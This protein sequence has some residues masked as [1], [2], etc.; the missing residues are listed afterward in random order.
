MKL[1][2]TLLIIPKCYF[3]WLPTKQLHIAT[4]KLAMA[5]KFSI[6]AIEVSIERFQLKALIE[7]T[8]VQYIYEEYTL[9]YLTFE[10]V[11][12]SKR[13][14]TKIKIMSIFFF[15]INFSHNYPPKCS[16]WNHSK[17]SSFSTVGNFIAFRHQKN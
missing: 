12:A 16:H 1:V 4:R 11:V 9:F 13:N 15:E 14:T 5:I 3:N 7:T 6:Y 2:Q 8:F 17:D 10:S